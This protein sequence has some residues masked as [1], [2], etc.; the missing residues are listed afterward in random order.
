MTECGKLNRK[1]KI[2]GGQE[3]EV[4][5]FPYQVGIGP[6]GD[7]YGHF[8]GGSIISQQWILTAAH[9]VIR[10]VTCSIISFFLII[11]V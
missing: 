9:C 3:T 8:C 2:V 6:K 4:H 10:F 5:E 1:I 11:L 7:G